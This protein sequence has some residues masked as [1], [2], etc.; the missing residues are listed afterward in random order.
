MLDYLAYS[1]RVNGGGM[2]FREATNERVVNG[3]R[4]VDYNNYKAKN[5]STKL[6]NLDKAFE[7]SELKKLSEINLENVQVK[8]ID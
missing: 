5:A 6:E 2:R 7:N 1:Y 4:F 8:L 3:V